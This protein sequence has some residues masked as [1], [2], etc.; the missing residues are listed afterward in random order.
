MHWYGKKGFSKNRKIGHITIVADTVEEA[1]ARLARIEASA[2][3]DLKRCGF[4]AGLRS[5]LRNA[6]VATTR[7]TAGQMTPLS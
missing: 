6:S 2:E 1:Q 5:F 4:S 3:E 7:C